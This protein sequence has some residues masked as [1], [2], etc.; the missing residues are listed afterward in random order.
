VVQVFCPQ[1]L[2]PGRHSPLLLYWVTQIKNDGLP[3]LWL[4]PVGIGNF[5]N[6]FFLQVEG[7]SNLSI[8]NNQFIFNDS[9]L[10]MDDRPKLNEPN[11]I[12]TT[13]NF[14]LNFDIIYIAGCG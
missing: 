12:I 3:V 5:I 10:A 13:D 1:V 6:E 11:N 14:I 9:A 7:Q 8:A 2:K 4:I